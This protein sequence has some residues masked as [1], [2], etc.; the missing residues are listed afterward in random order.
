M[1]DEFR[2]FSGVKQGGVYS[3]IL[4]NLF[5]NELANDIKQNGCGCYIDDNFLVLY[6]MQMTLFLLVHQSAKCRK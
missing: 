3:I 2:I 4:S 6:F 5:V 1:S